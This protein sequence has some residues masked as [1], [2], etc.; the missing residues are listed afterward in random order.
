MPAGVRCSIPPALSMAGPAGPDAEGRSGCARAQ[1]AGNDHA[2]AHLSP[3]HLRS[4][5]TIL[6]VCFRFRKKHKQSTKTRSPPILWRA[7]PRDACYCSNLNHLVGGPS[8]TRTLDPLI[9]SP[10]RIETVTIGARR[11]PHPARVFNP[12]LVGRSACVGMGIRT[13]LGQR[14]A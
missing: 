13:T 4:A 10:V 1:D 8:R 2:N 5:V 3:D 14:S 11:Y 9:K 6:E 12:R 7:P